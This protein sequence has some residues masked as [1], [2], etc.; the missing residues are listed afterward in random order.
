MY[1]VQLLGD[2]KEIR[3]K[4]LLYINYKKIND[5]DYKFPKIGK[6]IIQIIFK[7]SLTNM[8]SMFQ[9]CSS[10]T[11]LNLSNFNT[12]NVTNM[13][14]MFFNCFSLTSLNLSNFNTNNVTNMS[15]MFYKCSSLT[16]LNLSNFNTNNVNNMSFMFCDCSS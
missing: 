4:S 3:N 8:G 12:N 7:S 14:K 13:S 11:S 9:F 2:N 10:L 6:Y 1:K 16:S 15:Y 5:Y